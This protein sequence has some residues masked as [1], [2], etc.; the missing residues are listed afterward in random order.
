MNAE[1]ASTHPIIYFTPIHYIFNYTKTLIIILK[2]SRLNSVSAA[3]FKVLKFILV[4][5]SIA[6]LRLR[7]CLDKR[8]Q[9]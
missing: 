4:F 9:H 1:I 2:P 3:D 6:L 7:L 8:V 5:L